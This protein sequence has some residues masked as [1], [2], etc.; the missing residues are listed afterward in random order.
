MSDAKKEALSVKLMRHAEWLKDMEWDHQLCWAIPGYAELHEVAE[1]L[2]RLRAE[3]ER[4]RA[5]VNGQRIEELERDLAA[6]EASAAQWQAIAEYNAREIQQQM[7]RIA[8]AGA[9]NARQ[10]A[11]VAR[12]REAYC[13]REGPVRIFSGVDWATG[14]PSVVETTV[15]ADGNVVSFRQLGKAE[16]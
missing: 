8:Y 1:E 12:Y 15:D 9:V 4:W 14:E 13:E 16:Q 10:R 7:A 11:E 6:T 3:V 2:S 5:T